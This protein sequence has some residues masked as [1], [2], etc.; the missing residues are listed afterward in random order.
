MSKEIVGK[1]RWSAFSFS[2]GAV[3]IKV[4]DNEAF[5]ERIFESRTL[6]KPECTHQLMIKIILED[7]ERFKFQTG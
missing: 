4:R 6:L 7:L 2:N 1:L 3:S 5:S